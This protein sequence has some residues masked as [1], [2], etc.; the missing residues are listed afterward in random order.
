MPTD[1]VKDSA[2]CLFFGCKTAF[3]QYVILDLWNF[4][5]LPFIQMIVFLCCSWSFSTFNHNSCPFL[6]S[7]FFLKVWISLSIIYRRTFAL[8]WASSL[9][10]LHIFVYWCPPAHHHKC[11]RNNW[12]PLLLFLCNILRTK[13]VMKLIFCMQINIKVPYQLILTLLPSKF[14]TRW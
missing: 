2:C 13:W 3:A 6:Y 9:P 12:M 10:D 5:A 11:K 8:T 4:T 1:C 7:S 14:P